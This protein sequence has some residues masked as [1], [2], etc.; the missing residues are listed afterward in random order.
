MNGAVTS[1]GGE[2]GGRRR[3]Y[4]LP[5]GIARPEGLAPETARLLEVAVRR[6]LVDA[7][8]AA[9]GRTAVPAAAAAEPGGAREQTNPAASGAGDEGRDGYRVPSYDDG[10]RPVALPLL[11]G[12]GADAA[13]AVGR[14]A[15]GLGTGAGTGAG[16]GTGS[17]G[18]DLGGGAHP[19]AA[20][21]GTPVPPPVR[22]R[23]WTPVRLAALRSRMGHEYRNALLGRI[24]A[25]SLVVGSTDVRLV[26]ALGGPDRERTV[27]ARLGAGAF[28]LDPIARERLGLVA[29]AVPGAGYAVHR[30][31]DDGRRHDTGLRVVTRD[32]VTVPAGV[33]A[34][35]G[36]LTTLRETTIVG[37]GPGAFRAAAARIADALEHG[38]SGAP[39]SVVA[40]TMKSHLRGLDADELMSVFEELRRRGKLGE[41]LALVRVREFRT[42][43]HERQVPWTYV[44]A[45]WEPN[46]ADGAQVFSGV[47]WGAGENLY[48]VVEVIGML[49]GSVFSE[50]LARE[51]HRFWTAIVTCVGHP[52][53]T[54]EQGLRQLRDTFLEKLEQ[55]EFFDAGRVL[56]QL[57]MT[58]LT[59]PEAV[60]ALP[61]LAGGAVRAVV[62]VNRVGVAAL[63]SI[64]L[65]L[66]DVVRFLLTERPSTVTAE[67]VLLTVGGGDDILAAGAKSKGTSVLSR[68]E[69]GKGML[70]DGERLF[71]PAEIDELVRTLGEAERKAP[72]QAPAKTPAG[73]GGGGAGTVLTV[74]ALE[75]L[76]AQAIAEVG[77]AALTPATRGTKLHLAFARL[78]EARFAGSGL[79]VVPETSLRAFS[80]L[81]AEILDLPIETYVRRTP[82]VAELEQQLRPLFTNDGGP[83]L[84][85][86]LTPDLVVRAPG[87]LVVLDLTSV[88]RVPHMA[89]N[90]LYTVLLHESGEA[91]LVGETYWRH[92]G[93]TAAELEALYSREF[94]RARIQQ[95][96]GRIKKVQRSGQTP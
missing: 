16:L 61:K 81:P 48:Q 2:Q 24:S 89:K 10:G 40:A 96:A 7:V 55:L 74:E 82:G 32:T 23:D 88:E 86:D 77:G 58:L 12:P 49:A 44:L 65:R 43:L 34:Y 79:T 68:A 63:D 66:M 95:A 37:R 21:R 11:R 87:R 60:R 93:A 46:V 19:S 30:V 38:L 4:H 27:A 15:G 69:V 75:D 57:V 22:E 18:R 28:Y 51:R 91:A 59:L 39:G 85:G 83:R 80:R 33:L 17:G 72:L 71:T 9:G 41:A 84:V 14:P 29:A 70:E 94:R 62:S 1:E 64:G 56:G 26:P 67:G 13:G 35:T 73:P 53:V 78:V 50:Q 20:H 54:A 25:D 6:S 8:R 90:M 45:N 5:E 76:V 3:Y 47:L 52:L 92:F 31:T 36:D 42:F